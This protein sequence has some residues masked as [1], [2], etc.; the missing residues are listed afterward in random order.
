MRSEGKAISSWGDVRKALCCWLDTKLY[1]T[2]CD[3]MDCSP[4]SFSVHGI[5]LARI[6]DGL[7]F[8]SPGALPDSQIE[9]VTP[10]L[11][12]RF[13]TAEPPGKPHRGVFVL[14]TKTT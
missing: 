1:P 4:P 5:S 7:S 10:G 8:P 6:L 11:A 13:F 3:P 2:I 12:G 9:S 14:R